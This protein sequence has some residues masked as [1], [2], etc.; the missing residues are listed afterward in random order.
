MAVPRSTPWHRAC[1]SWSPMRTAI[2][3]GHPK[4]PKFM[5]T[6]FDAQKKVYRVYCFGLLWAWNKGNCMFGL[7][8]QLVEMFRLMQ[9][10]LMP[11][12]LVV[13]CSFS[14]CILPEDPMSTKILK[15][16]RPVGSKIYSTGAVCCCS[17]TGGCS[18]P[19]MF[20]LMVAVY[21]LILRSWFIWWWYC[22]PSL[23][24]L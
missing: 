21:H 22:N 11:K 23:E 10:V 9:L 8:S 13:A 24:Y 17:P 12:L 6:L 19:N 4:R 1:A 16:K 5:E 7:I 2:F 14:C 15:A 20:E 18:L 3:F